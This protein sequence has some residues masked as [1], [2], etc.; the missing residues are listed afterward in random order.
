MNIQGY[1]GMVGQSHQQFILPYADEFAYFARSLRIAGE[2]SPTGD[3]SDV[4]APR[5][6]AIAIINDNTIIIFFTPKKAIQK[7]PWVKIALCPVKVGKCVVCVC[8]DQDNSNKV[9]AKIF[10]GF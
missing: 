6:M 10:E 2:L 8:K 7:T 1:N 3:F 5:L 4:V 9:Y